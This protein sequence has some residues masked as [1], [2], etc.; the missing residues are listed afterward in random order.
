MDGPP[1]L[2]P[3]LDADDVVRGWKQRRRRRAP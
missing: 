2:L 3:P 1:T